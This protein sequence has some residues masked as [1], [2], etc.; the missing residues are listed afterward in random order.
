MAQWLRILEQEAGT[1]DACLASMLRVLARPL[2]ACPEPGVPSAWCVMCNALVR[3]AEYGTEV[4][5]EEYWHTLFDAMATAMCADAHCMPTD[6]EDA[7]AL[8]LLACVEHVL[9][10]AGAQQAAQAA[11]AQFLPRALEAVSY[12]HLT[13]PTI[14][15]V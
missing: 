11:L 4:E 8:H 2:K 12:T 7:C 5:T 13:L 6:E 14:Y 1:S 9:P 15:S 10:R 3:I